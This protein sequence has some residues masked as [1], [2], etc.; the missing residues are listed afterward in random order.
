MA[1]S[2]LMCFHLITI[3]PHQLWFELDAD[4]DIVMILTWLYFKIS[5]FQDFPSNVNELNKL[6]G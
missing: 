3:C 1:T 6:I 4:N 5:I 2:T